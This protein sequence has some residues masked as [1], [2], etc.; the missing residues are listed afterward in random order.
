M[1]LKMISRTEAVAFLHECGVINV[2]Q[3]MAESNSES[4]LELLNDVVF[5]LQKHV[6]FQTLTKLSTEASQRRSDAE[7][8]VVRKV[9]AGHGGLCFELSCFAAALL[10]ALDF[11]TALLGGR[12]ESDLI[13]HVFVLVYDLLQPGDRFAVD[14]GFGYPSYRA[15]SLDFEHESQ[16]FTDSFLTYKYAKSKDDK[17]VRL[18]KERSNAPSRCSKEFEPGWTVTYEFTLE[19]C[20]FERVAREFELSTYMNPRASLMQAVRVTLCPNG[21]FLCLRNRKV[22][23]EDEHTSQLVTTE[24]PDDEAVVQFVQQMVPVFDRDIIIRAVEN[25]RAEQLSLRT[26]A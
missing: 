13:N 14:V 24:L 15:V 19:K 21:R 11:R 16:T 20:T 3:R 5:S 2:E 6:P 12:I 23:R 10:A 1:T 4:R 26:S 7:E 22:Y 17:Y 25:C 8:T 18:H 9:L